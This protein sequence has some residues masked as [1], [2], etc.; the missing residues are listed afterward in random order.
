LPEPWRADHRDHGRVAA[1]VEDP[2]AA[3]EQ[4]DEL[5]VDDLHDLLAGVEALEDVLADR[6]LADGRDE[7]LDDLEVDV[8]L[9]QREPDLA[10]GGIDVGLADPT[11]AGEVPEGLAQALAEGVEH[12]PRRTPVGWWTGRSRR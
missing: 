10:H 3:S 9:E 1:E 6:L 5:V 2:V 12:G 4:L 8:G 7:L 11:P